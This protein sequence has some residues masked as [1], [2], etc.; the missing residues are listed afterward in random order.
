[1]K[2]L[3]LFMLIITTG[4]CHAQG[5]A[6]VELFT[7]QGCSSCP[8]ADKYL[9]ELIEKAEKEGKTIFALSFHVDYWNYIGW[10]DPYSSK[11]FTDRQKTYFENTKTTSIYTPQ[12]LVN[13]SEEFVGSNKKG[14]EGAVE[15]ALTQNPGTRINIKDARVSDGMIHLSYVLDNN[16]TG[17][18]LNLALVERNVENFLSRGENS[19]KRLHHDN[20]VR[21]FKS[22]PLNRAGDLVLKIP[23]LDP[24]KTTVIVYV[25]DNKWRVI[26]A[27]SIPLPY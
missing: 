23:S 18:I 1:M 14:I 24:S 17:E 22:F 20:V 10:R 9:S 25:Q 5:F 7:S 26:G 21:A 13:G 2:Y 6:I 8:A 19:G 4:N 11:E 12:V 15:S 27:T 3:V 16:S